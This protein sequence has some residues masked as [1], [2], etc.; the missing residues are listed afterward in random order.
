MQRK[1][2]GRLL[3]PCTVP[4][5][6]SRFASILPTWTA[7][8]LFLSFYVPSMSGGPS[9]HPR[10]SA[11]LLLVLSLSVMGLLF[12]GGLLILTAHCLLELLATLTQPLVTI[13]IDTMKFSTSVIAIALAVAA[14]SVSGTSAAGSIREY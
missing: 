2:N 4:C 12:V 11:H 6:R 10:A 13:F 7:C 14:P 3:S 9:A 5:P 1:E 8:P